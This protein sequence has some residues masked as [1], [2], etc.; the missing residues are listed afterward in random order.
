MRR[1]ALFSDVHANLAA[2]DAVL[3]V[4]PHALEL[5]TGGRPH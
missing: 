2:L 4:V 1:I 3:D 5:L